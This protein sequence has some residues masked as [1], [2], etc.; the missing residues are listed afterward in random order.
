MIE[1]VNAKLLKVLSC[2]HIVLTVIGYVYILSTKN[3]AMFLFAILGVK[4]Y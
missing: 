2:V 3:N 1:N 4:N